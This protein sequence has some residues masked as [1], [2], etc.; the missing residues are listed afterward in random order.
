M[1]FFLQNVSSSGRCHVN[2]DDLTFA[3]AEMHPVH[4][5]ARY[6]FMFWESGYSRAQN[7][8]ARKSGHAGDS[9]STS[10]YITHL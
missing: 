3:N 9:I 8:N 10:R 1:F 4:S 6:V 5:K 2:G 7:I